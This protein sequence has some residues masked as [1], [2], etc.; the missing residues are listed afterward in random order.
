MPFIGGAART[1]ASSASTVGGRRGDAH[2]HRAP[3]AQVPGERTGVH[4]AD[5]HHA[6]GGELVAEV[7]LRAPAARHPGRLTHDVAGDPDPLRLLVLVVD[8]GVATCGAV[9]TT[10]CRRYDGSVSVSW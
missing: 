5:A 8:A 6:G 3:L 1:V 2:A 9:I 7:T 4:A 10:T